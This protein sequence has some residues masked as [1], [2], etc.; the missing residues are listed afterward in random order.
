MSGM[1]FRIEIDSFLTKKED[2]L[3]RKMADYFISGAEETEYICYISSGSK[4]NKDTKIEKPYLSWAKA[5]GMFN[6]HRGYAS[7][8]RRGVLGLVFSGDKDGN[9]KPTKGEDLV[10]RRSSKGRR[11]FTISKPDILETVSGEPLQLEG[12]HCGRCPMSQQRVRY[13]ERP[14]TYIYYEKGS[15]KG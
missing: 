6:T 10:F 14:N 9:L 13:K 3:A 11:I 7:L 1:G 15:I 2:L 8:T 12:C 4:G 5:R